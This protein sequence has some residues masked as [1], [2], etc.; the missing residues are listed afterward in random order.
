MFGDV[1]V[2]DIDAADDEVDAAFDGDPIVHEALG[3]TVNICVGAE[4]IMSFKS[5]NN[6]INPF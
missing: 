1:D 4:F 2:G 3:T 6:Y 5:K